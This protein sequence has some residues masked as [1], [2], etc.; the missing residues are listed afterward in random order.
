VLWARRPIGHEEPGNSSYEPARQAEHRTLD[1][2]DM[3]LTKDRNAHEAGVDAT[4]VAGSMREVQAERLAAESS[5]PPSRRWPSRRGSTDLVDGVGERLDLLAEADT[6]L[7]AQLYADLG[8]SLLYDP[9][10]AVMQ[11]EA[12]S[13]TSV[14]VE[15]GTPPPLHGAGPTSGLSHGGTSGLVIAAILDP[16]RHL[17]QACPRYRKHCWQGKC[18]DCLASS[19]VTS[20]MGAGAPPRSAT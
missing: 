12:R 13:W 15:G 18:S 19:M 17:V 9:E 2:C 1:D 5:S 11:V 7:K 10:R 16:P 20:L 6:E 4:I 8:I 3:R 14:R